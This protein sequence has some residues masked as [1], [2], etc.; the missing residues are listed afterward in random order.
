MKQKESKEDKK[1]QE[2]LI[3]LYVKDGLSVRTIASSF[4]VSHMT[5]WRLLKKFSIPLRTQQG[6]SSTL[7]LR[8]YQE[9]RDE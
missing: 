9:G 7:L 1:L 5:L 3:E 4:K 2:L 6:Y 8:N